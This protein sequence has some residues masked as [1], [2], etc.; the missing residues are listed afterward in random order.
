A[1]PPHGMGGGAS[2]SSTPRGAPAGAGCSQLARDGA[3][4]GRGPLAQAGGP[5][6]A[7]SRGAPEQHRGCDGRG[8]LAAADAPRLPGLG[9]ASE[10]HGRHSTST[11]SSGG[12]TPGGGS[13]C[14]APPGLAMRRYRM[15]MAEEDFMGEGASSVCW[16]ATDIETGEHVAIKVY[17]RISDSRGR[18]VMLQK[19]TR[20]V[21]VLQELQEPL[22]QP[23]DPDLWSPQLQNVKAHRLFMQLLDYSKD[24]EGNPAPDEDDGIPYVVTELAQYSLKDYIQLRREQGK[25][26]PKESIRHIT[27]AIVLVVAGLHAKGL[28]HIDMKPENLMMFNGRLKLIDVDGCVKIGTRLSIQDSSISFSPCYCAP[29]WARFLIEDQ[30]TH[31]TVAPSLDVWSV[32]MT[33]GELVTLDAILKPT[34]ANFLCNG[35]SQREAGFLFMDWLSNIKKAPI[36]KSVEMFDLEFL[37]LLI[38]WLLVVDDKVRKTLAQSL[39]SPFIEAAAPQK[40]CGSLKFKSGGSYLSSADDANS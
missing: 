37:D 30:E 35:H 15:S 18:N 31:I 29:E 36:P 6:M 28:V 17:K 23:E 26:V 1:L 16:K 32:G 38:N 14:G 39:D 8:A 33:I 7:P 9:A 22:V 13:L 20:Q 25:P 21:R 2:R 40:G 34:Y 12:R 11:C 3:G 4:P 10:E 27:K 19:F 5:A 24:S